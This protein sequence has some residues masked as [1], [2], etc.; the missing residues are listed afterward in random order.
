MPGFI[1]KALQFKKKNVYLY[2]T[3]I[4]SILKKLK[5]KFFFR[6][7]TGQFDF[8]TKASYS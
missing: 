8:S 4:N 6:F 5:E 3:L 1:A 7:K 2:F